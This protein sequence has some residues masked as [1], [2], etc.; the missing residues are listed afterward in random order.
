LLWDIIVRRSGKKLWTKLPKPRN[1]GLGGEERKRMESVQGARRRKSGGGGN[2]VVG[3]T[4]ILPRKKRD[5]QH[6]NRSKL[7]FIF[8]HEKYLGWQQPR[9]QQKQAGWHEAD[10]LKEIVQ[11]AILLLYVLINTK[12]RD[13]DEQR[14][15]REKKTTGCVRRKNAIPQLFLCAFGV[16]CSLVHK[17]AAFADCFH[18]STNFAQPPRLNDEW[19]TSRIDKKLL[20]FLSFGV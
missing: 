20:N 18:A 10:E 6:H 7:L 2:D 14:V 16:G 19:R 3:G 9:Q 12:R 11:N 13:I 15:L 4:F 1:F 17:H 8:I 5:C